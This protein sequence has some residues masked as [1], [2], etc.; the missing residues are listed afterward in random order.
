MVCGGLPVAGDH[1][2]PVEG[3]EFAFVCVF[4]GVFRGLVFGSCVFTCLVVLCGSGL[5][6]LHGCMFFFLWAKTQAEAK[7]TVGFDG[8]GVRFLSVRTR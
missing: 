3:V 7:T 5:V 4:A 8:K 1:W 2:F 6:V